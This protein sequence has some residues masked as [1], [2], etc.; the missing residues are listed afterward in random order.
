VIGKIKTNTLQVEKLCGRDQLAR[1]L[2][3]KKAPKTVPFL[4]PMIKL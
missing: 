1:R 3:T 2:A 4:E